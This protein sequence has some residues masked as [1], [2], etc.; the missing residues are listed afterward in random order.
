VVV[1]DLFVP[2]ITA[3]PTTG[4]P[5]WSV[6]TLVFPAILGGPLAITVLALVNGRRLGV[7]SGGQLAVAAG[8]VG[9]MALRLWVLAL[10]Q[11]GSSGRVVSALAGALAYGVVVLVQRPPYRA[12]TLR[13]GEAASLVW[14]GLAAAV[15]GA[16]IE[17]VLAAAVLL[18][19]T[20]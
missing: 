18:A 4:K 11:S 1:N 19:V 3:Q 17:A 20:R 10:V 6:S 13:G 5:P 2:T 14:P 12:F 7:A 9:A 8:G 16:V 15:G